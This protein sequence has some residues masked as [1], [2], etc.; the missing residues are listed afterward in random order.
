MCVLGVGGGRE[1]ENMCVK[2]MC[3][4]HWWENLEGSF[5]GKADCTVKPPRKE[6]KLVA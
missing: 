4:A 1:R 3:N 2:R 5:T 6:R